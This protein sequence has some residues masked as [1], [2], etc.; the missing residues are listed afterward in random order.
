MIELYSSAQTH[1]VRT[2]GGT[3]W[4]NDRNNSVGWDVEF[5]FLLSVLNSLMT[6]DSSGPIIS[7]G[8]QIGFGMVHTGEVGTAPTTYASG[9]TWPQ[10]MAATPSSTTLLDISS[11]DQ[12]VGS[13]SAVAA[14]AFGCG[15]SVTST[16][17][18]PAAA[19]VAA[20]RK[21]TAVP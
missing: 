12:N 15:F 7:N 1:N 4:T 10:Q 20:A 3:S 11:L 21:I 17:G 19:A 16:G 6:I 2:S 5:E 18:T 13:V 14:N 9:T 8:P